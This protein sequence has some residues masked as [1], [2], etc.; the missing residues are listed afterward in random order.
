MST[1]KKWHSDV[2]HKKDSDEFDPIAKMVNERFTRAREWRAQEMI[3]QFTVE[4]TLLNCYNQYHGIPDCDEAELLDRLNTNVKISLTKHKVDVLVAWTRDLLGSANTSPFL[5]EPTPIP[6]LSARAKAEVVAKLRTQLMGGFVG[7]EAAVMALARSLKEQQLAEEMRLAQNASRAMQTLIDDQLVESGFRGQLMDFLTNFA[8]YPY[9]VMVGP[10]PEMIP[11]FKWSGGRPV[12]SQKAVLKTYNVSPFDYYWSPD[13]YAAGKGTF[14]II[15]VRM[16]KMDLIRSAKLP[17]FIYENVKAAI[18]KLSGPDNSIHWLSGNPDKQTNLRPW[19]SDDSID[20]L[21]HYGALSGR[22]LRQYGMSGVEDDVYYE[23][24]ATVLGSWTIRLV[25]NP[26][27]NVF[28]RS[29]YSASYQRV[30]GKL[31]GYGIAQNLRDIERSFMSAM[32]GMLENIGFSSAPMGEVD[33]ARVQRYMSDDQL[34]ELMSATVIPTDPDMSGGG[35]PAHYFHN[36]PNIS[37]Q[38]VNVMQYFTD[39][40]DRHTGIPAAMSGQP[41]GTGVNRTFRGIMALYGNALKGVQSALINMDKELFEPLGQA[42]FNY[43]MKYH[44]DPRVKGDSMVRARGTEGLLQKE[45]ARQGSIEQLQ[46]IAQLSQTGQVDPKVMRWAINK[47]LESSGVPLEELG[48]D[49]S[50][51]IDPMQE[52]PDPMAQQIGAEQAAPQPAGMPAM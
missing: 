19:G 40:A 22:E 38:L 42:Y 10:H 4:Q 11:V 5:V 32:R 44:D 8:L 26:N 45:I 43:N 6:D 7:D 29:I 28:H 30:P 35:R 49:T 1:Q 25:M 51:V 37:G 15:K 17:G 3:G 46:L 23:C 2:R 47:A 13:T 48:V 14:D 36:V 12:T 24:Q 9:A 39:L 16:T 50:N 31:P 27:P 21:V 52:T 33:F 20:L 41:V 18:K 34:G